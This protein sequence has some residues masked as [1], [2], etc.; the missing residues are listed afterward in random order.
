[1]LKVPLIHR[2]SWIHRGLEV[3]RSIMIDPR[4]MMTSKIFRQELPVCYV[5][6]STAT[7]DISMVFFWITLSG[8]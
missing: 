4:S 2:S 1:M 5:S 3:V 6:A 8:D 7:M